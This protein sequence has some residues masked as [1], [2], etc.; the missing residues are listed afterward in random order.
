MLYRPFVI[1]PLSLHKEIS[2][3]LPHIEIPCEFRVVLEVYLDPMA[4]FIT[5]V[6]LSVVHLIVKI[7]D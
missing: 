5:K 6:M 4:M 3:F 2:T 7:I 1:L